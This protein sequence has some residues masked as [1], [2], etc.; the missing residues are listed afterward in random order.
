M[1]ANIVFSIVF[2]GLF[3]ALDIPLHGGLTLATTGASFV[4]AGLLYYFLHRNDVWRFDA[5]WLKRI[6][7]FGLATTAMG[8]ALYALLPY[9]PLAGSEWL[10]IG[11]LVVLCAFGALIYGVVLLVTG[12][13]PRELKHR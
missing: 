8:A 4:N 7:Q 1:I 2:I 12:F 5:S 10:R 11:A 9:F 13:R 3:Y 6:G